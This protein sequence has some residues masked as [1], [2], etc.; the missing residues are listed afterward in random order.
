M[1][2]WFMGTCTMPSFG[3]ADSIGRPNASI[4]GTGGGKTPPELGAGDGVLDPGNPPKTRLPL[5]GWCWCTAR[6]VRFSC[7]GRW[8]GS[9]TGP[10]KCAGWVSAGGKGGGG[11]PL[12]GAGDMVWG[13]NETEEG[14][15]GAVSRKKC[16]QEAGSRPCHVLL[17]GGVSSP[18]AGGDTTGSCVAE[19]ADTG[20]DSCS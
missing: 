14:A 16:E 10:R 9:G 17:P 8:M 18:E 4:P 7:G 15:L 2:P 19:P 11:T 1:G 20:L 13:G 12:Y 5:L 3:A 6:C